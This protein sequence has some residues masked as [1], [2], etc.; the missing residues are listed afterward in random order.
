MAKK[1]S[2]PTVTTAGGANDFSR[3]REFATAYNKKVGKK[4]LYTGDEIP[5]VVKVPFDEPALDHV[6]DG[7]AALGRFTELLGKEH[8]GKTRA[9]LRAMSRFQKFCFNCMNPSALRVKWKHNAK[10]PE[11]EECECAY[12]DNPTTRLGMFI[13]IEGSTDRLFMKRL[14]VDPDGVIYLRPDQPQDAANLIEGAL[15]SDGV[16]LIVLDSFG[17]MGGVKE[18][19]TPIDEINMNQNAVWFNMMFRKF[20]A[21]MNASF[22]LHGKDMIAVIY[23]NQS[24]QSLSMYTAD[25]PQGGRGARHGKGL[26]I[27]FSTGERV[28]DKDRDGIIVG[29]HTKVE[30]LKNKT[31]MPY[32]KAEFYLN[33]DP[34]N[35]EISYGETD[36]VSQYVD[37]AIK[38][39]IVQQ[40]GAWYEYNGK[41]I[42]GK[43]N[44]ADFVVNDPAI[45]E[46]VDKIL[47]ET[48]KV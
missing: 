42:N 9:A 12:C 18:A 45:K 43:A 41:K 32:R 22:N 1:A 33:L 47:Y 46:D 31:G 36:V 35:R 24:Y 7:G 10:F 48:L 6:S 30:N 29:V 15:R 23:V 21:A 26:S 44:V 39:G 11:V 17:V 2:A 8:T 25:V 38:F 40:T 20:Q 3:A 13:D 4:L 16:G 28:P 19:N 34:E 5:L 37:F 14:G 27:K